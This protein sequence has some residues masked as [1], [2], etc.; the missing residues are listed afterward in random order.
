LTMRTTINGK[1]ATINS[2]KSK[3]LRDIINKM[4]H[5]LSH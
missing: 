2:S 4:K 1:R 5:D 3:A